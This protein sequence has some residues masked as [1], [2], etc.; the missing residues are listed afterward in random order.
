M[1]NFDDE[2]GTFEN[3]APTLEQSAPIP[4]SKDKSSKKEIQ[5][6]VEFFWSE[7]IKSLDWA[8]YIQDHV[9]APYMWTG[10]AWK[11]L[12]D[13][14][15]EFEAEKF[16]YS[17]FKGAYSDSK[18]KSCVGLTYAILKRLNKVLEK[19]E[20]RSIFSV[21]GCY[22]EILVD[23]S[24]KLYEH[25]K[26]LF[27][28]KFI[29][30]PISLSDSDKDGFYT[31]LRNE[32]IENR[33]LLGK[34]I[35]DS[36]ESMRV[37]RAFQEHMGDM[38][39]YENS[40]VTPFLLG[41]GGNGKSQWVEMVMGIFPYNAVADLSNLKGFNI[42]HFENADAIIFDEA[43]KR[44]D[45]QN[46]KRIF[47]GGTGVQMNRKH[48]AVI[49]WKPDCKTFGALNEMPQFSEHS[50]AILRRIR[51]YPMSKPMHESGERIKDIGKKILK[52]FKTAGTK[53]GEEIFIED[54]MRDLFDWMLN[55]SV[56]VL[57]RGGLLNDEDM[58][59]E[60]KTEKA[61]LRFETEPVWAFIKELEWKP[62]SGAGGVTKNEVYEVYVQWCKDTGRIG[63]MSSHRFGKDLKRNFE[64]E[65]GKGV[66][67]ESK[68]ACK[69]VKG[70]RV[71]K[72]AYKMEAANGAEYSIKYENFVWVEEQ[73]SAAEKKVEEIKRVAVAAVKNGS[74]E[75]YDGDEIDF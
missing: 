70:D 65:F 72:T 14:D 57:K 19:V 37:R 54:Q 8:M 9:A 2:F 40:Q 45:E 62:I 27:V 31:P 25:D 64:K 47:G 66:L 33:G 24:I 3:S 74:G 56:E 73:E 52:G 16:L 28:K 48:K 22:L 61:N 21:R 43:E 60:C 35:R 29:D 7:H 44:I 68:I 15:I 63:I 1:N 36:F 75:E 67:R 39:L 34:L 41:G 11:P 32:D 55:G 4:E 18:K 26:S 49:N 42:E 71:Q 17:R 20:D 5:E 38:F 58:P 51:I 69:T 59:I 30:V 13:L 50:E 23:G 53:K 10:K 6:T 46:F 12:T